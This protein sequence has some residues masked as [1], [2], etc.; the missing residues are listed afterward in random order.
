MTILF[1]SRLFYPHIGGVEKHVL[2]ISKILIKRGYKL[3]VIAEQHDPK[4]KLH[5]NIGD[6]EVY[7]ISVGC[8]DWFKKFRIWVCLW[9]H[10][11]IIEAADIVH[12][13]DVFFWFL[14]FRF[15]YPF[16]KV[17]TTFHGYETKFPPLKKTVLIRKISEKL[18]S[19]NICV[20]DYLKKWYGTKPNYTTYGG[21]KISNIIRKPTD[22]TSNIN[23]KKLKIL[24]IGRLDKDT[25]I[26]AYLT[27]LKILRNKKI[28]FEFEICGDGPLRMDA[29]SYGRVHG[30]VRDLNGY[31]KKADIVFASSYL[32]IL[33]AMKAK[34]LIF[35]TFDNSLKEEYLKLSPFAKWIV[36]KNSPQETV[37]KIVYYLNHKKEIE[38]ITTRAYKWVKG[39][40][41]ERV[42][43]SY[44]ALWDHKIPN[45]Q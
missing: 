28:E 39:Q 23:N 40:T 8:D 38:K 9:N 13:H 22:Q 1:F 15:I 31:I 10:R 42:L 45:R 37:R 21:V 3:T 29:E 14:P 30:F 32:S 7:R 41:W 24:F 20:G 6:I 33:E 36:I 4:L 43:E 25:G 5:D 19:G 12:C 26:L 18:S 44:M 34:K 35:S 27:A 17:Y 2:E 16:K 11:N